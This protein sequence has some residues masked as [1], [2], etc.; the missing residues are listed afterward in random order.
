MGASHATLSSTA[1]A[2]DNDATLQ[3][4]GY[5]VDQRLY[6]GSGRMMRTYR[7]KLLHSEALVVTK[8]MYISQDYSQDIKQHEQ[9]LFKI[10][11]ALKGQAHVAP[12]V[13][14]H[15]GDFV[16]KQQTRFRPG[17]FIN[18]WTPSSKCTR[19]AFATDFSPPKMSDSRRGITL[20]CWTFHRTKP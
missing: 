16:H 2:E 8:T 15:V 5:T 14:W 3:L 19:R 13:Y 1:T 9:E 20:S 18:Y 17:L 12:F 10:K 6:P 11:E 7:L 4:P